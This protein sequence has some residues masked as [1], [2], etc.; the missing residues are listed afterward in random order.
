MEF[1]LVP[2]LAIA[3]VTFGFYKLAALIFHIRLSW[4]LLAMLVG[5]AW[6]ISLVLP[7]MFFHSAGFMGSV[8]IS[9]VCAVG[10][11]WLAT[12][13]DEKTHAAQF[14]IISAE[15]QILAEEIAWTPASESAFPVVPGGVIAGEKPEI[16]RYEPE[17]AEK[18]VPEQPQLTVIEMEKI[19]EPALPYDG[20]L[21]VAKLEPAAA[22]IA[23]APIE[24][25]GT[26][27]TKAAPPV[28]P[29]VGD[30]SGKIGRE[31]DK[32]V[33]SDMLLPPIAKFE[34]AAADIASAPI[35]KRGTPETKAAPPVIP[36]VGDESEKI[37][38]ESDR[39]AFSDMLLSSIELPELTTSLTDKFAEPAN[40][41]ST[42]GSR[43]SIFEV[44]T[45]IE[46]VPQ[47]PEVE[48]YRPVATEAYSP[49][50]LPD[51]RPGAII[52]ALSAKEVREPLA[53]R[54]REIPDVSLPAPQ[55]ASDSLEDL[56]EF[57]F[58]QRACHN[59]SGALDA[60]RLVR[61]QYGE[62]DAV[63]LVAAE[64]VSTLQSCGEYEAA[65]TELAGVLQ[66]GVVRRDRRLVQAFEQKQEYLLALQELLREQGR[67]NLPFEQIPAE[68]SEWLEW[69]LSAGTSAQS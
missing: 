12:I 3:G 57:A 8:G 54:S 61:L 65:L 15:A 56:L 49:F 4:V 37:G 20:R 31:S 44:A 22:D 64:V 52:D 34:P 23:S 32:P 5:F 39:P 18:P 53:A 14:D 66:L 47:L 58:E 42:V 24:K 45:D 36:A 33:F 11:A 35:E 19:A 55:P 63:P 6:L 7:G 27:E 69:K 62:S 29:A 40:K 1:F 59:M 67:P 38:R 43:E 21:Q 25:R 16:S 60:F 28:I 13:Y 17:L 51:E 2:L 46:I 50:D 41:N 30:E 68:W 48:E 26:P 9:L 10:F